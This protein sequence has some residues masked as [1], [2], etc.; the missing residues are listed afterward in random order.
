MYGADS[1]G[2]STA[3]VVVVDDE[4]MLADLLAE[5]VAEKWNC[6]AVNGGHEALDQVDAG[7]DVVLLDRQMLDLSGDEVLA[8]IREDQLPCQ[9]MMVSA[10]EPDYD[11]FDLPFDDYLQKPVKRPVIQE[12]VE[13]LLLRRTYHP[14]IQQFFT[15]TRKVALLETR[16]PADELAGHEEYLT[17]KATAD[18]LRQA[19]D[20]TLG[21]RTPHVQEAVDVEVDD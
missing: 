11:I 2:D 7:T 10:A 17:L 1:G 5:W 16:K 21:A 9:V 3:E 20:A 18:E 8:S 13:Q 12:R 6:R 19:A 14:D 15:I 4:P